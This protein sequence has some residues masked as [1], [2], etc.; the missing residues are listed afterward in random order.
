MRPEDWIAAARRLAEL[1]LAVHWLRSPKPRKMPPHGYR[2][3][4]TC[5]QRGGQRR[6]GWDGV[7][8]APLEKAWA[9]APYTPPEQI[10]AG[11]RP[12]ANI[13]LHTGLVAGAPASVVVVDLDSAE[14]LD[15]A[16]EHLPPSPWET[17]TG[18]GEHWFYKH[19]G[20]GVV[21][22]NKVKVDKLDLDIRGDGGQVVCA[23]SV[24][25]E[26]HV[27]AEKRPW[28]LGAELPVFDPSWF[29]AP[30]RPAPGPRRV[31]RTP[32]HDQVLRRAERWLAALPPAISGQGGHQ[33]L[34]NAAL[35]LVK[36]FGLS[37]GEALDLLRADYSP[38]CVPPWSERELAHKVAQA[39]KAHGVPEGYLRDADRQGY[40][41]PKLPAW[42]RSEPPPVDE[43]PLEVRERDAPRGRAAAPPPPPPEGPPPDDAP[44]PPEEPPQDE[45]P[46]R[47]EDD[48]GVAAGAG[49][50]GQELIWETTRGRGRRLKECLANAVT[51]FGQHWAWQGV[52]A[53]NE[54]RGQV[55]SQKPPPWGANEASSAG[56]T[57]GPWVDEDDTRAKAWLER[58]YSLSLGRET[59]GAAIR[60][61]AERQRRY[62]PV[63]EYL[64]GLTWDGEERLGSLFSWYFDA[65]PQGRSPYLWHVSRWW[66]ISAVARIMQPGC[67]ADC[68]IILEGKQGARKSS[69]LTVLAVR[70]EWFIDSTVPLE[71]KDAFEVLR[72][73]WIVEFAELDSWKR[74]DHN[75]L[76][77][78]LSSRQD[79]YR[80]AYARHSQD[81]R[82]QCIFSGST[83]EHDYLVDPTGARR[84]WPITCG[85]I[86][87]EELQRDR[88]QLWAEAVHLYRNGARWWPATEDEERLCAEQQA[89]R[90]RSDEW[91]PKIAAWLDDLAYADLEAIRK[92]GGLTSGVVLERALQIP[93]ERWQHS[94]QIRVGLILQDLGYQRQQRRVDGQRSYFYAK[95]TQLELPSE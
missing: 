37:E 55:E 59:V 76:K 15:W 1:G 67:K 38:R 21:L 40:S 91:E 83:N 54:F 31:G 25:P 47:E 66:M 69:A 16:R 56:V 45:P 62:H 80:A 89:E 79:S 73:K 14:A 58:E 92:A 57:A 85:K 35:G 88:D 23:P 74:A 30:P 63:R 6:C 82:R 94:Q 65:D 86:R 39:G 18:A 81:H 68:M 48:P 46:R 77:N 70:L 26:G 90:K 5:P 8:K 3:N 32:D 22:P 43:V 78:F 71:N 60:L 2:D 28:E 75:R 52:L 12:G 4:C 53:F 29:P 34:W 9:A 87:L 27:Y 64:E 84:F 95:P 42:R 50:W 33:Q 13:G 19:P 61:A 44:P 20:P 72:G 17:V 24:H 7:G 10:S 93:P 49:D 11:W 51:I 36:G 41:V